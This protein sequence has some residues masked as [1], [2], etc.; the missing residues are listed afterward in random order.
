MTGV[1]TT[2][3]IAPARNPKTMRRMKTHTITLEDGTKVELSEESY[4][5]LKA[6]V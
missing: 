4:K 2:Q 3:V 1:Q 5:A 6:A